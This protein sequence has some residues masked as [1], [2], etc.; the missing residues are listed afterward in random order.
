MVSTFQNLLW[1]AEIEMVSLGIPRKLTKK[2]VQRAFMVCR[3]LQLNTLIF[4]QCYADINWVLK[5]GAIFVSIGGFYFFI[6]FFH[7][8]PYQATANLSVVVPVFVG[9]SVLYGKAFRLPDR[10]EALKDKIAVISARLIWGSFEAKK[11][12]VSVPNLSIRVGEFH[13]LERNSTLNFIDFV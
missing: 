2:R 7:I 12:I 1:S 4:N 10:F 6:S 13:V 11:Q 3:R 5:L 9:F 8:H